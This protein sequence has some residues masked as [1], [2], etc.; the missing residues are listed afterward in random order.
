MSKNESTNK[1]EVSILDWECS[2]IEQIEKSEKRAWVVAGAFALCFGISIVS[3]VLMMP[4]KQTIPYLIR[5]NATTGE[6]N[7]M[8]AVRSKDVS[9]D[10]IQDKYW[11]GNYIRARESYDWHTIENDYLITKELSQKEVFVPVAN[12]YSSDNAPTQVYGNKK[13]IVIKISSI[14]L[15]SGNASKVATVR[16]SKTL[17]DNSSNTQLS[18]SNWVA[19]ISYIYN[20]KYLASEKSRT[21]N[22]FG[23]T[24]SSYRIDPEVNNLL[25]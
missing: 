5:V 14:T 9:F 1:K 17:V 6:I 15:N 23:F 19:T 24:V 7:A 22:P 4:L 8:T 18:T 16:L 25:P 12:L 3:I 2:R 11:I 21:L 10:E 13:R 20:P